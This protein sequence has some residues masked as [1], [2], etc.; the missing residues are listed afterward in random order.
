VKQKD[1]TNGDEMT[2]TLPL[3]GRYKKGLVIGC[4]LILSGLVF[5]LI[6]Y[7]LYARQMYD[8]SRRQVKEDMDYDE[9]NVKRNELSLWYGYRMCI[10][11]GIVVGGCF[12]V[13]F[14]CI[15]LFFDRKMPLEAIERLGLLILVG[16]LLLIALLYGASFYPLLLLFY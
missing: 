7:P 13:V 15:L 3:S 9:Y 11:R 10:S 4:V 8:L 12:V 14:T 16:F 1:S 6:I 2:E 5:S